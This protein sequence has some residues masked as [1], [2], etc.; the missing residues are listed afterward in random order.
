MRF[1]VVSGFNQEKTFQ[2]TL[3]YMGTGRRSTNGLSTGVTHPCDFS[4]HY[5]DERL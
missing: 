5:V 3:R 4:G 1:L 2:L